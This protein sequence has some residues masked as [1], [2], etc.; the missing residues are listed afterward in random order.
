MTGKKDGAAA[1]RLQE[2]ARGHSSGTYA[3]T[4]S[5]AWSR[6]DEAALRAEAEDRFRERTPPAPGD[7]KDESVRVTRDELDVWARSVLGRGLPDAPE[8]GLDFAVFYRKMVRRNRVHM[9]YLEFA[10]CGARGRARPIRSE[11]EGEVT[12]DVCREIFSRAEE[13]DLS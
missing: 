2:P 7:P 6:D 4:P 5:G 10:L 1:N 8:W 11:V 13:E 3:K 12:C 9:T